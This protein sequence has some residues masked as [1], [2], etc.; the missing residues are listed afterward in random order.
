MTCCG[1]ATTSVFLGR[2]CDAEA[3]A[4][5]LWIEEEEIRSNFEAQGASYPVTAIQRDVRSL[6]FQDG[7]F[8]AII[9]IE[10]FGTDVRLIPRLKRGGGIGMTTPLLGRIRT[11][12]HRR[13]I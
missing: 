7:E 3:V 9:C 12:S 5:D 11:R 1:K 6:P 4:F 10:Y 8:D 13:P 2:E